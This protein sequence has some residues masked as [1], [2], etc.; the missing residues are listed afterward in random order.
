MRRAR[1]SV[2]VTVAELADQMWAELMQTT[3]SGKKFHDGGEITP[4]HWLAAKK[5][6]DQIKAGAGPSPSL[7]VNGRWYAPDSF[8]NTPIAASPAISPD[9]AAQIAWM[10]QNA[11]G[12]FGPTINNPSIYV[13][14]NP[15][16][17]LRV[18]VNY[19]TCDARSIDPATMVPIP[20]GAKPGAGG[21][22]G[23]TGE[24]ASMVVVNADTG[25]EWDMF[26]LTPPNVTPLVS[27]PVCPVKNVWACTVLAYS[28][29]GWTGSGNGYSY[30]ASR[31][32]GGAGVIRP[33]ETKMPAG[34]TWDHKLAM[35]YPHTRSSFV[36]PA[37]SS[38]GPFTDPASIPM[39]ACIQLDPAFDV[40]G[41]SLPEWQK[42]LCRTLQKYGVVIV[43][44]GSALMNEGLYSVRA[45]GYTWP[46][47]PNWI[48]LP[49]SVV[50]RF[51]VLV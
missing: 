37:S 11:V 49:A 42:Q 4:G 8:W 27:G 24:E 44:T 31:T 43:D 16:P 36:F 30:R 5:L 18:A 40:D 29:P 41:S 21:L 28:N 23:T 14:D 7:D 32:L 15:T 2:A 35:G 17:K 19:P 6:R 33:R 12:A 25:E 22:L 45:A 46:W 3:I 13:A 48:P 47:E 38:D 50:S 10:M 51:R 26:K 9:N 1:A 34:S 20:A 39:G